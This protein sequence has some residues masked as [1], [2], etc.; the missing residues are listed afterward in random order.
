MRT[1]LPALTNEQSRRS[2]LSANSRL[3]GTLSALANASSVAREGEIDA[4]SIFDSMPAEIPAAV[5][6][7]AT[8]KSSDL[9]KRRTWA[10][11]PSSSVRLTMSICRALQKSHILKFA[12][13]PPAVTASP[14][15][16]V[17]LIMLCLGLLATTPVGSPGRRVH[18][19]GHSGAIDC[20]SRRTCF[21]IFYHDATFAA[22]SALVLAALAAR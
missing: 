19:R 22:V 18:T 13:R 8:V 11:I 21:P 15:P 16:F 12:K 20:G 9:R 7:S 1:P 6:S 17:R 2:S 5:P 14:T 4:F 3:T 10:P